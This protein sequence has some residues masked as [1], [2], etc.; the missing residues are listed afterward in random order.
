MEIHSKS[1]KRSRQGKALCLG[2]NGG[3]ITMGDKRDRSDLAPHEE[4]EMSHSEMTIKSEQILRVSAAKFLSKLGRV[5]FGGHLFNIRLAT[6][7]PT[8][9]DI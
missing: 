6:V 7:A 5:S 4:K 3:R 9:E 1:L 2:P 8:G